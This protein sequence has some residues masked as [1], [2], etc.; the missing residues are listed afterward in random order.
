MIDC[1]T[2]TLQFCSSAVPGLAVA[3][4]PVYCRQFN[5]EMNKPQFNTDSRK[6]PFSIP[7]CLDFL[8]ILMSDSF[9]ALPLRQSDVIMIITRRL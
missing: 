2:V 3:P 6:A 7:I 4:R 8:V 9:A 1:L 5:H